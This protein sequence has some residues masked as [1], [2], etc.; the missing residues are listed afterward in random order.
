ME[1]GIK[2]TSSEIFLTTQRLI[3][4]DNKSS[5]RNKIIIDSK[6]AKKDESIN[7]E[8]N[9]RRIKEVFMNGNKVMREKVY[10]KTDEQTVHSVD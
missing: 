9:L 4:S 6:E 3:F 5:I 8:K 2:K 1:K 10:E 7:K